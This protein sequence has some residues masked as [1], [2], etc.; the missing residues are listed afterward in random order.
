[1]LAIGDDECVCYLSDGCDIEP[2]DATRNGVL[3]TRN[4]GDESPSHIASVSQQ[5]RAMKEERP[6]FLEL[7]ALSFADRCLEP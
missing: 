1:M 3:S 5:P 2:P 4:G 7:L 6:L